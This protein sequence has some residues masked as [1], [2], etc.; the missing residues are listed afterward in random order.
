MSLNLL[1]V[2]SVEITIY[3]GMEGG[4]GCLVNCSSVQSILGLPWL[5]STK[6]SACQSRKHRFNPWVRKIPWR[7]KWKSTLVLLPGKIHGQ[8]SLAGYGPWDHK[9]SDT[10]QQPNNNN[11]FLSYIALSE[12]FLTKLFLLMVSEITQD[13]R[14]LL[15]ESYHPAISVSR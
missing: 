12:N 11:N 4:G 13:Q 15:F 5:F 3:L 6:E 14:D 2:W 10:T 7:T 1:S 8:R 9:K